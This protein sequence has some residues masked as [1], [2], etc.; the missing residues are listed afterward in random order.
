M[1]QTG[2]ED[3]HEL[4]KI[5][6]LMRMGFDISRLEFYRWLVERGRDPE[7]ADVQGSA[8]SKAAAW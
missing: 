1:V 6:A 4:L 3:Q 5:A 2:N 8:T 7:W